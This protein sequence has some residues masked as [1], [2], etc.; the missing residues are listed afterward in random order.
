[1]RA[2]QRSKDG[3]EHTSWSPVETVRTPDGPPQRR[4]CSLG[5]RNSSAPARWLRTMEV[6]P[7]QGGAQQGKLFPSQVEPPPDD[8]Q[9][10]RVLLNKVRLERTRQF[11]ACY[12]GLERW[13][14]RELDH[15][16]EQA[17][18]D[19]PAHVLWLRVAALLAIKRLWAPGSE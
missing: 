17:L 11:G 5:E 16:F 14:R 3:K 15:F 6:F 13:K 7:E 8:P 9:R 2:Q 18:D 4:L 1:L 19:E 10:A 12:L